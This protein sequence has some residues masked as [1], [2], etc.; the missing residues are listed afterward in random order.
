MRGCF[1]G[2]AL[3]HDGA[4][5]ARAVL[6]GCAYALR[7]I[8]DRFEALDL[9][10]EEI[11]VVGGGARSPLWLQIKADVTGRPVRPVR[12]EDATSCGAAMLA[13]VAAGHFADLAEAAEQMVE[14]A[15]EPILPR[16]E[17][18][19]AYDE[20]YHAY[21]RLFDGVEGSLT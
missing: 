9:A 11:R 10:G 13:G 17:T 5:L 8:V 21:R 7:D 19:E 12:G 15:A 14:L 6:E 3:N 2:L 16:P 20:A 18:F 4:H 1:A